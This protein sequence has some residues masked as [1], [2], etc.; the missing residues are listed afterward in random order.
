MFR[1]CNLGAEYYLKQLLK[2]T[3]FFNLLEE[4]GNKK[5]ILF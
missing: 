1:V 5:Y 3:I 4:T 2:N